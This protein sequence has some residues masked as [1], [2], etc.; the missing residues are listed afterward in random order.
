MSPLT[1]L[2]STSPVISSSVITPVTVLALTVARTPLIRASALTVLALI[3]VVAGTEML[4]LALRLPLSWVK[5]VR[6][7]QRLPSFSLTWLILSVEPSQLTRRGFPWTSWTSIRAVGES[8]CVTMSTRPATRPSL[9]L[10]TVSFSSPMSSTFGPSICHSCA[11]WTSLYLGRWRGLAIRVISRSNDSRYNAMYRECNPS[12][13][14]KNR[15]QEHPCAGSFSRPASRPTGR[16]SDRRYGRLSD[17]G[18]ATG[19][20]HRAAPARRSAHSRPGRGRRRR[21]RP[22]PNA[23]AHG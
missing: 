17:R 3:S 18:P 9:S 1:V 13:P 15:R 21:P 20:S 16:R 7:S 6:L 11:M 4:T 19:P 8:S 23:T 5:D 22:D 10:R 12:T 14:R 2:A